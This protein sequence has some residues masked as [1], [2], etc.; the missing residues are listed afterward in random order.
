MK[1]FT[2]TAQIIGQ[3]GEEIACGYL[4]RHGYRIIERNFTR[5]WG[6]IDIIARKS[7]VTCF[8]EVKSVTC[9]NSNHT[10]NMALIDDAHRPEDLIHP[11]KQR[12][13]MRTIETYLMGNSVAEWRFDAVCVYMNMKTRRARVKILED[14][15]LV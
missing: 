6:E 11:W 4:L 8:I 3:R 15:I 14:I 13:L 9:E 1:T 7:G 12:K 2:S 5:K 10:R